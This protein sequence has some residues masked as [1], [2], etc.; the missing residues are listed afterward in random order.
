MAVAGNQDGKEVRRE[1]RTV[2]GCAGEREATAGGYVFTIFPPSLPPSLPPFLR[3]PSLPPF[4]R[5]LGG[6]RP[7][8]PPRVQVLLRPG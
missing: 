7:P 8:D 4:L 2:S 6:A 3:P 1:G 5:P